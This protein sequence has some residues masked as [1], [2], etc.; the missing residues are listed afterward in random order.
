MLIHVI[1]SQLF[2]LTKPEL[3]K[4]IVYHPLKSKR[5]IAAKPVTKTKWNAKNVWP[6]ADSKRRMNNKRHVIKMEN[7][8][9]NG[10]FRPNHIDSYIK[11]KYSIQCNCKEE[12]VRLNIQDLNYMLFI[13]D[14]L[15]IKTQYRIKVKG[16]KKLHC[17]DNS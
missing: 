4:V 15:M 14:A 12:I 7:I 11:C 17:A 13:R 8:L 2:A 1:S 5:N 10:K 3:R 6:R 9:Q 16:W